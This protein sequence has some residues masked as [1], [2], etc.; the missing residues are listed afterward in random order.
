MQISLYNFSKRKNSTAQPGDASRTVNAELKSNTSLI[1]PVFVLSG[2]INDSYNYVSAFGRYYF[3]NDKTAVANGLIELSC[4]CDFLATHKESIKETSAYVLYDTTKNIDIPDSR[5]SVKNEVVTYVSVGALRDDLSEDGVCVCSLLSSNQVGSYYIAPLD[6]PKLMPDWGDVYADYQDTD[7]PFSAAAAFI[8]SLQYSGQN[9]TEYVK[10][11]KWIPMKIPGSPNMPLRIG[12]YLLGIKGYSVSNR[13]ITDTK[14]VKIPWAYS[15]WRN[16][17][18]YAEVHVYIPFI[19]HISI[20]ASQI[21]GSDSL[22]FTSSVDPVSGDMVVTM[23]QEASDGGTSVPIGMY[24]TNIA[25]DMMAGATMANA[26]NIMTGAATMATAAV[27]GN[28]VSLIGGGLSAI[29]P[30][31]TTI[32][33]IGSYAAIG[34]PLKVQI[35]LTYHNT[36]VEPSSV[37][38]VIGTPACAVKKL[39]NLSGYV[40]TFNASIEMSV[41]DAEID[42]VNSMLNSGIYLE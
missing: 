18:P 35:M 24:T 8:K 11:I 32:G 13:H 7:N 33:G 12:S 39:G 6:V 26:T 34:Q 36:I 27:T 30:T 17:S 9:S 1:N 23:S 29:Q 10:S 38:S 19:G 22:W 3:I 41:T 4:S 20:P 5:L 42:A 40:Q 31:A 16:T 15:D 2:S 25:S 21:V 28:V 14:Q 37:S